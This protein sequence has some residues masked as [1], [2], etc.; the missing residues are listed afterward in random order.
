MREAESV[1]CDQL[2][3]E[4][5]S[6]LHAAIQET[7]AT[8]TVNPLPVINAYR[9]QLKQLF[10]NLILNAIKFR[11]KDIAPV[12]TITVTPKKGFWQLSIADNGI[13]IDPKNQEKVFV[14][15]QRLHSRKEYEG[16]GIGLA[17]CKKIVQLHQGT[18]WLESAVGKGST[19]YFTIK[20]V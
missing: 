3:N 20:G 19:F 6:D 12:I 16:S 4:V 15:F 1:N 7:G 13:G 9:T 18:I 5:L 2:L 14:M 11:K 8:I 17:F 10:Q